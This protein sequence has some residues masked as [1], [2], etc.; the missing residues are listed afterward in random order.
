MICGGLWQLTINENEKKNE[1]NQIQ[2]TYKTMSP[3][4]L[5]LGNWTQPHT[6]LQ[7]ILNA[8]SQFWYLFLGIGKLQTQPWGTLYRDKVFLVQL[9]FSTIYQKCFIFCLISLS[10]CQAVYFTSQILLRMACAMTGCWFLMS[11]VVPLENDSMFFLPPH[12]YPTENKCYCT[13]QK[14]QIVIWGQ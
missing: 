11:S 10:L 13:W 4:V 7:K 3:N 6:L 5:L 2:K 14:K 8:Y 12:R 1:Q 9:L